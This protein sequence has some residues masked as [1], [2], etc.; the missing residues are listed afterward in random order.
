MS[1][2]PGP[3]PPWSGRQR[4]VPFLIGTGLALL[5]S[6]SSGL[7]PL[8]GA[9]TDPDT[10]MRLLRLRDSLSAGRP[11][12]AVMRDNAGHGTVLHWSHLLDGLVLVLAAPVAAIGG[13]A[14]GL[15]WVSV[16]LGPL[17]IGLLG[18]VVA[19]AVLPLARTGDGSVGP[20]WLAAVT[21]GLSPGVV[22]YGLAGVVHHH[23]LLAVASACAAGWAVRAVRAGGPLAGVGVGISAAL[24]L[25]LSPEAL[26]FCLMALGGVWM[27][28]LIAP[29]PDLARALAAAGLAL[30]IGTTGAWLIDPPA[31]G[32]G[33]AEPDRLSIMFVWL[34]AGAALSGCSACLRHWARPVAVLIG[35]GAAVA[36]LAAY[37]QF[38]RGTAGLMS[39]SQARAFF[40]G[41]LEMSPVQDLAGVAMHLLRGGLAVVFLT[42]LGW[43][44]RVPA[45]L[46][47]AGCGAVM[48]ALA[49]QH[50]RFATYPATFAAGVLPVAIAQ[51]M[52]SSLPDLTVARLRTG[53]IGVFLA[54]PALAGFGLA[55]LAP[56]GVAAA[57]GLATPTCTLGD[58]VA[59]TLPLADA[60]VLAP[61][62]EGPLLLWRTRIR[63]VGSLYHRGID[64]FMRLQRAWFDPA[65]PQAAVKETTAQYVLFCAQPGL[66]APD[67]SLLAQLNTDHVPA[68]LE[69]AGTSGGYVLYRIK[70]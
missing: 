34:G 23:I 25:W 55:A 65:D 3:A 10:A 57:S 54:L 6:V 2:A 59:L 13:W 56:A 63:T 4:A 47:A 48:V 53:T 43:R 27:A 58:A 51:L 21:L 39:P 16:V 19:W 5:A 17:S 42:W 22:Q 40:D 35:A 67:H 70:P 24:G 20:V 45:A 66:A 7:G 61:V 1:G 26:P 28:W 29:R 9:I 46:Y 60:V 37:P 68:W 18:A 15:T 62:N 8:R 38:M 44:E 41:I 69:P 64:G 31:T 50:V 12:Q 49:A 30:F 36:W 14:A 11:L 33:T 32:Y 52:R